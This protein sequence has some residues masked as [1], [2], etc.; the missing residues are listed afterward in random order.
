MISARINV[1]KGSKIVGPIYM[2]NQI[3]VVIGE[4]CWIGKDLSI[5]GNG[6]V[7]I[8][9]NV[10]VAPHV[11]INTGGH[12]IGTSERRAAKGIIYKISIGNGTWI[13]TKVLIINNTSIGAGCVVAAG[14]VVI[15]NVEHNSLVAGVPA[16]SKR[17]LS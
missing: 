10:D 14:S 8:G 13:G 3:R 15:S 1:G 16:I 11:V 2:G 5:D 17:N 4:N 7:E 12:E 9:D 6:E